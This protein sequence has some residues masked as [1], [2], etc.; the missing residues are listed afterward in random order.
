MTRSISH[1]S[2]CGNRSRQGA[3]TVVVLVCLLLSAMLLASLLKLVWLQDG[4]SGRV[5]MRLQ[6]VWLADSGFERAAARMAVD[7]DY[8]GE[9]WTID[10]NRLGGPDAAIVVIRVDKDESHTHRRQVEVKAVYPAEG[11]QQARLIR[12]TTITLAQEK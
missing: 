7:P 12:Q 8:S 4:Q 3:F 5:Q 9:T 6:A 11:T 1:I 10:A 2:A